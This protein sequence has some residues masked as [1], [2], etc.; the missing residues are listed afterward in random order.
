MSTELVLIR[1]TQVAISGVC[2]GRLDVPL[3]DSFTN[4][5]TTLQTE[6]AG[7]EADRVYTSPA[8]RCTLLAERLFP[9]QAMTDTRLQELD[10]GAW[11]G[12]RWDDIGEPAITAWAADYVHIAPPDGECYAQLADR[13]AEFLQSIRSSDARQVVAITHAGVIR[14]A[15]AL[16]NGIPLAQSFEF[17]PA[18]GGIFRY[19]LKP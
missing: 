4:D 17:Q 11:E 3:A 12:R 5:I 7:R 15:H 10:F 2:Y 6:C 16:L 1:H 19:R 14:A 18:Y 8:Q 9:G 13:V